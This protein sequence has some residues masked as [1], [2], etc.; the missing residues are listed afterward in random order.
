MDRIKKY[1]KAARDES[2]FLLCWQLARYAHDHD[3]VNV[4]RRDDRNLNCVAPKVTKLD[5]KI[6]GKALNG[7]RNGDRRTHMIAV[8]A[9][10]TMRLANQ[11][12]AGGR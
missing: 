8:E 12:H 6:V 7:L 10:G 5:V 11:A 9:L 4:T 1:L 3:S 2:R